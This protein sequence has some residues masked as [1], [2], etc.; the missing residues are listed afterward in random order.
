MI[1]LYSVLLCLIFLFEIQY[2][3]KEK[4]EKDVELLMLVQ[5]LYFSIIPMFSINHT[6]ILAQF[7]I[8]HFNPEVYN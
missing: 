8:F 7:R 3:D 1:Y 5:V 6:F 4:T 2:K